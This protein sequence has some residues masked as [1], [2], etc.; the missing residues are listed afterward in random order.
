[1]RATTPTLLGASIVLTTAAL[2]CFTWALYYLT[3]ETTAILLVALIA[4]SAL[5]WRRR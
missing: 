1:M 4:Y 3:L 5:A 2:L